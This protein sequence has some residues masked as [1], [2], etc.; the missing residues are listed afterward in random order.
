MSIAA[1]IPSPAT[2]SRRR[3]LQLGVAAGLATV[4]IWA[5]GIVATRFA[6]ATSLPPGALALLR[7]GSAFLLLLPVLLRHGLALQRIGIGKSAMIVAG[8]GAPFFLLSSTGTKFAPAADAATIMVGTMPI[9]VA[10]LSC[11]LEGERF[12]AR[13]L[14]GFA[15][16]IAG[17]LLVGG[18]RALGEG[19]ESWRG[20]ALF[21]LSAALWAGYTIALRR[22]GIGAWHAAALINFYSL[23]FAGPFCFVLDHAALAAAP[24][25]DIAVQTFLQGVVSAILGL[26]FYG[27]AVRRLGASRA[28]VLGSLTPVVTALLAAL[29]IGEAPG[30]PVLGAAIVVGL[31]VALAS[32]LVARA[33]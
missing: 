5:S 22:A 31:G 6:V 1:T 15:L 4:F 14:L 25:R 2:S 7:Y 27:E 23:L 12:G 28:A 20:H 19:A 13:R 11:L 29:V 10:L 17:I 33:R 24:W 3:E 30:L 21:I 18:W 32:G 9:L 16:V 26:Y 8:A